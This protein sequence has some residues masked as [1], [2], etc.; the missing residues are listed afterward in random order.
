MRDELWPSF[1][2]NFVVAR[3]RSASQSRPIVQLDAH[4]PN[5]NEKSLVILKSDNTLRFVDPIL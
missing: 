1:L 5:L 4:E 2:R 3:E